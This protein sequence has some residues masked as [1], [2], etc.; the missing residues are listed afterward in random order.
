MTR[1]E[2][3]MRR[4]TLNDF[5][6]LRALIQIDLYEQDGAAALRRI[7]DAWPALKR[8]G[9]LHVEAIHTEALYLRQRAALA[10][11]AAGPGAHGELLREAARDS[12]EMSGKD[13]RVAAGLRTLGRLMVATCER[14][15]AP[16]RGAV[17]EVLAQLE[18]AG[19]GL[20]AAA[21]RQRLGE[22][23]GDGAEAMR[24]EAAA[25][26]KRN[27]VVNPAA[28]ARVYVPI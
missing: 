17:D 1:P 23:I 26:M 13:L 12:A 22:L 7:H 15:G 8:S 14:G 16:E 2:L 21:V 3:M 10:V 24:D 11:A 6:Y 27:A 20:H 25:F 28:L 4:F 18:A 19:L 9:L 5:N